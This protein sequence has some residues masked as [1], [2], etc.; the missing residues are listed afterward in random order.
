MNLEAPVFFADA[1]ASEGQGDVGFPAANELLQGFAIFIHFLLKAEV[2]FLC[3]AAINSRS[4]SRLN[5]RAGVY[6]RKFVTRLGVISLRVPHVRY[7]YPRIS[8]VKRAKRLEASLLDALGEIYREG[9]SHERVA[10]LIGSL[11]TLE[12]PAALLAS[13]TGGLA[14]MLE[15]WRRG[16]P[17][18]SL[19]RG[20]GAEFQTPRRP[21]DGA[22]G[23]EPAGAGVA[24][25]A[26]P[27]PIGRRCSERVRPAK[28]RPYPAPAAR[29]QTPEHGWAVY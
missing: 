7:L 3:G 14:P 23:A 27:A 18:H 22:Q 13:L 5:Y 12:L 15:A 17:S 29:T 9:A 25:A 20:W 19:A 21:A 2:D 10:A 28:S 8:L 4:R 1:P 16:V 26:K 24:Q 6:N 11:W